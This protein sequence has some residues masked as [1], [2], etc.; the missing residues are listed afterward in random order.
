MLLVEMFKKVK[1]LTSER[2]VNVQRAQALTC[3]AFI[4]HL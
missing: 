1:P 2:E 3:F 4:L